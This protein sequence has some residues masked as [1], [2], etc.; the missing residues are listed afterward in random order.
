MVRA[1]SYLE[2]NGVGPRF[3]GAL[4]VPLEELAEFVPHLGWL[5]R[6]IAHFPWV[7]FTDEKQQFLASVCKH[8]SLHLDALSPTAEATLQE[9]L[10]G[11]GFLDA[12]ETEC[13]NRW[14]RTSAIA[15]R[16]TDV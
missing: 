14:G 16:M 1:L 5:T 2:R 11:S 7:F 9:F 12:G 15:G 10:P 4:E 8:C 3:H 13:Y 6:C